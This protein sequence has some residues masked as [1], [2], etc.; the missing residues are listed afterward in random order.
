MKTQDLLHLY[1]E[2]GL[3]QSIAQ[4]LENKEQNRLQ[5]KGLQGSIDAVIAATVHQK[6]PETNHIYVLHDKEEAAYFHY[7]LQNLL[8]TQ[9]D[10]LFF[11]TSYKR[12][13]HYEE[14]ENANVLQRAEVLNAISQLNKKLSPLNTFQEK[15][16]GLLIVTY[17]EA[18][19]EKVVNKQTLLEHT[20]T[21]RIGENLDLDFISELLIEYDFEKTDFVYEAGQFAIRG[22]IID[23]FSFASEFPFRIELFGDEIESIRTFN[24]D[25][26]LSL[27]P[28]EQAIIVPNTQT[29]LLQEK[30]E[31]FLEFIPKNSTIWLKNVTLSIEVIEKCF[32]KVQ[33]N[34]EA[35][36]AVSNQTQVI[37]N[38]EVLFETKDNFKK[39]LLE[40]FCVEFGRNFHFK[41]A[42]SIEYKTQ[43]QPS[44]NKDFQLLADTLH[45]YQFQHFTNLIASDSV[46]QTERLRSIF[47][48]IKPSLKVQNLAISLQ[49]GFIDP[50]TQIVCFTDHQIFERFYRYKTQ[51]RFSKSK[52]LTLKELQSLKPGDFVT[53][54]DYG[55]GR[56]AGLEK[57]E[58]NGNLQEMVRLV[59]RDDDL[60][61]VNIHS[62]HKI[63][64]F[65]ASEGTP[66]SISK[67]G[68]QEWENKK[69]KVKNKV[70]DIAKD[71]IGLY[72]KRKAALGFAFASDDFMQAE[73]ESSFIYEDTPDQAKATA[74]V[75]ADM[76]QPHP[77][78]RLVCGDVGFGK[79]EVAIRAAF[80]AVCNGK[81]AAVLVPTTILAMQHYRTFAERLSRFPCRVDYINRFRTTKEIKETLK[82]VAEGKV[83][84]L[85]GTHRILNEDV[86]FKDL[87]IMI[88]DEEQ[89]FGVKAKERLKE[90][91]L[92]IDSLTLTATPIPRTLHF[93]LMGARDLSVISTPPPN[94]QPVTT[95]MHV[96]KEDFI[97]DVVSNELRRGGQVF[98]VHN[99]IKDIESLGN[100][101]LKLVPDARIGIAHGQ[102]EGSILEKTM[103]RFI[104]GDYD[105][106][107]S[108]NIIE[109]GLDIPNAN[110]IIINHAHMFGLSDL[111]QMRGR[112]G[113]SNKKAYCYL[114]VPSMLSLT[115]DAQK[116]L[117]TLEEFSELGDGFKV[118]MRDL[119]IRGAGD[120][121][122]AEQSGFINDL[123]F[124]AYHK[125]LDEAISELKES[126]FK[127]L[128]FKE[129]TTKELLTDCIIETDLQ[130]LIPDYY[131]Q[132]I[133]ERLSLY[134]ELDNVKNEEELD[135]FQKR[136]TD[137]F[138]KLPKE[139]ED[140]VE[141]VRLRWL[142]EK[143]G[144]EKLILKGQ[145]LKGQFPSSEKQEYYN[146]ERFG[147]VIDFLQKNPKSA[148][149]KELN[150]RQLMIF[151]EVKKI[152]QAIEIL[153]KVL[154]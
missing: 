142:A 38:P 111:H 36:L 135:K 18:L 87:G 92:N 44:F 130:M 8:G 137:R 139:V 50:N 154:G 116:R 72:A 134:N 88:I 110:T 10:I 119:D 106:L 146:S 47:E 151:E 74:D 152:S 49:E 34:F 144:F 31:S 112:V 7:D 58:V 109:S 76:E 101:I 70:K 75:K 65:S 128:F 33:A 143:I 12:P 2:D 84:I 98:F 6:N 17:P 52:A 19:S 83:D 133:S 9:K 141:T 104:E 28:C 153:E 145:T 61:Y 21:A 78:D 71:L 114:L 89:K 53:H 81:Q 124:E 100:M 59:Y 55:I 66:P 11:P 95:E 13:Y 86:K 30:R 29:K 35:I 37:A 132:S 24:P 5:I 57:R 105:V 15:A 85:I 64:R 48:E 51:Q 131:V 107:L 148:K 96:F 138:G 67:L 27:E 79:T 39:L 62:L 147:K 126:E 73:L 140:L 125:I 3:I 90:F 20:Y 23:I 14:I 42:P 80:K 40:F 108:T 99:R 149:L 46:K 60:L 16:K 129:M 26:Q 115:N 54:I 136:L 45:Q 82:N 102:M 1:K 121:L 68:S 122:G 150:K 4:Y 69:A 25:S 123:G 43:T 93:S 103:M 127:D 56:F 94:R 91:R 117:K 22:G 97:R 32:E 63:S 41:N 120:L 118:A 113:R 77:M